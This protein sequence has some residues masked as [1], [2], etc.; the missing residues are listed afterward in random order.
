MLPSFAERT[1]PA[2]PSCTVGLIVSAMPTRS[3]WLN[4]FQ[5]LEEVEVVISQR[6]HHYNNKRL[7]SSLAYKPRG[8]G[9][10]ACINCPKLLSR[11]RYLGG[12]VS[13]CR[14]S[15]L[16]AIPGRFSELQASHQKE[17]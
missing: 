8:N 14:G 11:C 1:V 3:I 17:E 13:S 2:V 7:H 4:P 6:I 15:S 9:D 10:S 12:H 16:S 5:S